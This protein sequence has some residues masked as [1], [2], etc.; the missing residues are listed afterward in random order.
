VLV[1]H[2]ALTPLAGSPTRIVDALNRHTEIEAKLVI[3]RPDAYGNRTFNGGINWQIDRD[4]AMEALQHADIVHLHH[5][6]ELDQNPFG[7]NFSQECH[8]ASFVRQFHTHPLTVA[9]GDCSRA[10]EIVESALPQ[11]VVGQYHERF[12]P[13]ARIVPNIVPIADELYKPLTQHS[14]DPVVYFAPTVDYP[15]D[16]V[17][18]NGTR[19]ET[20]G[21]RETEAL[22]RRVIESCGK[23]R[24]LVRRNIAHEQCLRE[25]QASDIAIDEMV[26]GSFH[27][28]SLEALAQGL[29]TFAYLDSRCLDTL[30][31]LTGTH[32]HPWLNVRLEDA[33]A[34]LRE[35]IKDSVLRRE[36]GVFAHD[37]MEKY[38][39]ECQMVR[40]YV[41]AYQDILGRPESFTK[42]RFDPNSHRQIFLAQR[43]DELVWEKRITRFASEE[44]LP[45][46]RKCL[47]SGLDENRSGPL[48]NWIKA[49][50]HELIK[51]YTSVRVDEI[52]ALERRAV[53]AENLL[54]FVAA[55]ETH[56]WLYQNRLERMDAT[57]DIFDEKRREFHLDRYRF[58]CQRVAGKR[59][60]DCATGTGYGVRLLRE[61][62]NAAEVVGVDIE[63]RAIRYAS[64][65][66]RVGAT[67]FSLLVGRSF[68]TAR[69]LCRYHRLVRD[70]RT[71]AGRS[72]SD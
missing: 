6:F 45:P 28:S 56:R 55:D 21:A 52:K 72:R 34:S 51:K 7:I 32:A 37:W 18:I 39:S 50:V 59:V 5:Y 22:L 3:L 20:K 8:R 35:L 47:P 33:E 4:Q 38:Y 12:F 71:C 49:P 41:R 64:K 24:L 61:I 69:R 16:I 58:A 40:H 1:A 26:T 60:L 42:L 31:E 9:G 27:L 25:K 17:P 23:G 70:Y 43:R 15:A 48:P 36:L 44:K 68:G 67:Q 57:L 54:D 19:W 62:G 66:H 10:R 53:N 63:L 2:V 30:A 46:G 65:N 14:S 29:P 11:L 13:R